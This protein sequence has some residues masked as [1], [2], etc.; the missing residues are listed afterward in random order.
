MSEKYFIPKNISETPSSKEKY[1]E[2]E[3][4]LKN[5]KG[6]LKIGPD[7]TDEE[8]EAF[9]EVRKGL[10]K[11]KSEIV[12]QA[13]QEAHDE[14]GRRNTLSKMVTDML[15]ANIYH[16]TYNSDYIK[17]LE[18][19][20]GLLNLATNGGVY[21]DAYKS[22]YK[23]QFEHSDHTKPIM[24]TLTTRDCKIMADIVE[25]KINKAKQKNKTE[26]NTKIDDEEQQARD[27]IKGRI[28]GLN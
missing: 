8:I 17:N 12:G 25:D 13:Y 26:E 14:D 24:D 5:L 10:E 18:N 16:D 27:A 3:N 2:N 7:S 9:L 21:L 28:K 20:N 15:T 1:E 22:I 11:E 4:D 23:N 19:L 6:G